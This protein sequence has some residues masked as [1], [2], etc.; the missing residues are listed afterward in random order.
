MKKLTI[1]SCGDCPFI[2]MEFSQD[3]KHRFDVCGIAPL[4]I[5]D[6]KKIHPD[7]D[8]DEA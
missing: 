5:T 8:L 1:N 2:E 4:T 7:C 3:N 6:M